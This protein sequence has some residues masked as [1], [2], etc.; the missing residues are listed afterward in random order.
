MRPEERDVA[1]LWDMR[2]AARTAR[3]LVAGMDLQA[4]LADRR[5]QLAVERAL[6]LVGE[7]ARRVST[8]LRDAHPE[9]PWRTIVGL[10]NVL[11]HDYGEIDETR[12]FAVAVR[13]IPA[14]LSVLEPLLPPEA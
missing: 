6:E 10:R 5:T 9:L 2:E 13:D 1:Y 11:V 7:A 12:V 4:F 3:D 8:S 14:L